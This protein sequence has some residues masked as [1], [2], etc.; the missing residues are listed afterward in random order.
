MNPKSLLKAA[1]IVVSIT[2]LSGFGAQMSSAA[3]SEVRLDEKNFDKEAIKIIDRSIDALGGLEKIS[4]HKYVTQTGTISI[5]AAGITGTTEIRISSPDKLIVKF[6]IPAIGTTIQGLNDGIAWST[7]A[8]NGPRILSE[9]EAKEVIKQANIQAQIEYKEQYKTIEYVEKT[10]FDAQA[11]HKIKLVDNEGTESVEY[12]S[13][14]SGLLIGSEIQ[15][16]TQMGETVVSSTVKDYKELGGQ[17]QPTKL[18]Q[19]VG[20]TEILITFE[21]ADYSEIDDGEFDF[22]AAI[23]KLIEIRDSKKKEAP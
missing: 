3:P 19:K 2:T 9:A 14:E 20:A 4:K 8:M 12:Y 18:V 17:L 10:E 5:P 11:A 22:P 6:D 7:D 1:A 21:S 16:M 15:T 13:I 23:Q